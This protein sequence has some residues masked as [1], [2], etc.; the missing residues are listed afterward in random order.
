MIPPNKVKEIVSKH[1]KLEKE[2]ASGQIDKD[3]FANKNL[4]RKSKN[5]WLRKFEI[6]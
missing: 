2:L 6:I 4:F 3:N 5:K 1:S